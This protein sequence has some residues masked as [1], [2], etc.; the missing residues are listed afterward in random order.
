MKPLSSE[1]VVVE[2][3]VVMAKSTVFEILFISN[4]KR[5][6]KPTK[7][8]ETNDIVKVSWSDP[9][10]AAALKQQKVPHKRK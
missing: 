2:I 10:S 1:I 5:F 7:Y 8:V 3:I 4:C 6:K 9:M